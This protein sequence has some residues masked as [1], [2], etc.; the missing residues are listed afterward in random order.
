MSA[1]IND[2]PGVSVSQSH[3]SSEVQVDQHLDQSAASPVFSR[4]H[5]YLPV[6][7][8]LA[9]PRPDWN[10][11]DDITPGAVIHHSPFSPNLGIQPLFEALS[12]GL[13]A[14]GILEEHVGYVASC[15]ELFFQKIYPT[16]PVVYRPIL[17]EAINQLGLSVFDL[18]HKTFALLTATCA[19]TLAVLPTTTASNT[20]PAATVFYRSSRAALAQYTEEDIENPD[21]TSIVIR[22]FQSGWA[23]VA[24][25][26]KT[27]WNMLGECIR[28]AQAMRLHDEG[29]YTRMPHLEGQMCR[30]AFWTLYTG[31]KSSAILGGYP[32]CLKETIF[33]D[34]VPVEYPVPLGDQDIVRIKTGTGMTQEMSMLAGFNSN[35]DMWRAAERLLDFDLSRLDSTTNNQDE[36]RRSQKL[37]D[38]YLSEFYACLDDLP[39]CLSLYTGFVP[40]ADGFKF[41]TETRP[42]D[43]PEAM[44]IQRTNLQ[45]SHLCLKML[46]TRRIH[47]S[48]SNS[49]LG[50]TRPDEHCK[51]SGL[52]IAET[53]CIARDLLYAIHTSSIELIRLNGEACVEKIRLI[54]ASLLELIAN[55]PNIPT[56]SVLRQ[57]QEL[58]PHILALLD[59]KASDS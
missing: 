22:M 47:E 7:P 35:Q 2:S 28:L 41:Q 11:W 59:S 29:T 34:V 12:H 51:T 40:S 44:E 9:T 21:H 33:R 49:D 24:G 39:P 25:K 1:S 57:Y 17:A 42:A 56:H 48:R 8:M 19:Y 13:V 52:H 15:I 30:R 50:W 3:E 23:H 6:N 5:A 54:G 27:S 37:L 4:Y 10:V 43:T 32:V 55:N 38:L 45:V 36:A 20:W 31:D 26:R 53:L 18:D 58:F 16:Y 14:A 46:I